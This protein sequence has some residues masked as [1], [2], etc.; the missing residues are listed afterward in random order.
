MKLANTDTP[1]GKSQEFFSRDMV[2]A[3]PWTLLGKA[4]QF[5]VYFLISVVLVRQLGPDQYGLLKACEVIGTWLVI[6]CELGLNTSLI[7]F[8]PELIVRRSRAGLVRL[9]S[10]IAFMQLG[11]LVLAS[12]V[13][14]FLNPQIDTWYF[15]S[16]AGYLLSVTVGVFGFRLLRALIEDTLTSLYCARFASLLGICAGFLW[17]ALVLIVLDRYGTALAALAIQAAI[18]ALFA[19]CGGLKVA[20]ILKA[21]PRDGSSYGVGK[22]RVLFMGL[23]TMVNAAGLIFLRQYSELFFLSICFSPTLAGIYGLGCE[24]PLMVI[25]FVPMALQTLFIAGFAE[26][27]SRDEA[28]LGRLTAAFYRMLILAVVPFAAFGVFFSGRGIELIYGAEMKDA[29]PI[30]AT[31][32]VLHLLSTIWTPLSMAIVA[33]EK[34]PSMLWLTVLQV[35][36]NIIFDVTLIPRW[37]M[38]GAAAAVFL[39]FAVAAPIQLYAIKRIVGGIYFPGWFFVKISVPLVILA[40]VLSPLAPHLNVVTLFALGGGYL[41]AFPVLIRVL[42]LIHEDEVSEIRALNIHKLNRVMDFFVR[43]AQA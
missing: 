6:L 3:V 41:A 1:G 13:L 32:C 34:V 22:R 9:I 33:K 19:L 21:F 37:G 24:T 15:K 31:F 43:P 10:R 2:L 36:I 16:D 27:Y 40:A 25:G 26:A 35:I 23:S 7:R 12:F 5:V 14:H 28:C 38:Y 4:A 8:V 17:L 20:S 29:G 18:A 30:A 42:R 11:M 39:T